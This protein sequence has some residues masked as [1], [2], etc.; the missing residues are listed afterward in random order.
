MKRVPISKRQREQKLL[1]SR[2]VCALCMR[3]IVGTAEIDHILPVA[4]GGK[5][6]LSNL[7]VLCHACH[8]RVTG[9]F[10]TAHAKSKRISRTVALEIAVAALKEIRASWDEPDSLGLFTIADETLKKIG[11]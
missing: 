1:D 5:T 11:E 7:R 9:K 2:G 4:A 10:V 6:V 3:L 8:N